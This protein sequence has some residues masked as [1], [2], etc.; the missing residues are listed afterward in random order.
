V[1]DD[2]ER[3]IDDRIIA[4][5]EK[6]RSSTPAPLDESAGKFYTVCA[7]GRERIAEW[8]YEL[9]DAESNKATCGLPPYVHLEDV[10]RLKMRQAI[11]RPHVFD[12]H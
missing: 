5:A 4:L 9:G 12:P 8:L 1:L 11:G 7:T 6:P 10:R 3:P 2:F